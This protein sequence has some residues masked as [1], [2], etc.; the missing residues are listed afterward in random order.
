M[1]SSISRYDWVAYRLKG[2]A[3]TQ[4]EPDS[5]D[6]VLEVDPGLVRPTRRL[7]HFAVVQ[8]LLRGIARTFPFR[9]VS[10]VLLVLAPMVC[11]PACLRCD[12]SD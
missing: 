2:T 5:V 1:I 11:D 10:V 12:Q 3:A 8:T 9:F 7:E 4:P 6:V